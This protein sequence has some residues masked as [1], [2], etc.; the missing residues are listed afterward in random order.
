MRKINLIVVHCSATKEGKDFREKDIRRWHL[1]RG[2]SDIGYH[3]VV[4][5]DGTVEAGR[6]L[7]KPGA[8][9]SGHNANSIGIVYVGGLDAKGKPKDT[10][11]TAQKHALLDLLQKLKERFPAAR[12]CGHRDLS[13][14]RN[15]DGKITPNE[16]LKACPCFDAIPEYKDL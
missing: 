3:Y 4:D 8:H 16:W 2:F 10:R 13:P 15:H 5:L 9:V 11:T 14:D 1:D 7:A 12:I 6:N